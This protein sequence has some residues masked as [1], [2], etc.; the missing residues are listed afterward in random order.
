MACDFHASS[1]SEWR[2]CTW[3]NVFENKGT[4]PGSFDV[5]WRK[6]LRSGGHRRKRWRKADDDNAQCIHCIS[7]RQTRLGVRCNRK[8][9][10]GETVALEDVGGRRWTT[11]KQTLWYQHKTENMKKSLRDWLPGVKRRRLHQEYQEVI[12]GNKQINF[13]RTDYLTYLNNI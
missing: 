4:W 9:D 10:Y 13:F 2:W 3:R 1:Q 11:A 5:A 6:A 8:E 7:M 12:N